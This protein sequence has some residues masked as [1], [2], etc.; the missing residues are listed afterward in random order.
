MVDNDK[1]KWRFRNADE[2]KADTLYDWGVA[3]IAPHHIAMRIGYAKS[4]AEL[5]KARRTDRSPHQIQVSMSPMAAK[6]LAEQ[7]LRYANALESTVPPK[8]MQN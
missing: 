6:Q 8:D 2:I 5:D 1:S 7:L 3:A 4:Q